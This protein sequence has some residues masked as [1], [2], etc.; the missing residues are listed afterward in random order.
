MLR[1]ELDGRDVPDPLYI[2]VQAL[3]GR[4]FYLQPA[5]LEILMECPTMAPCRGG[6]LCE[7][8]GIHKSN[9]ILPFL[10]IYIGTGKTVMMIGLILATR[11]QISLPEQSTDDE[12]A[13]LTPLAFRYFPSGNFASARGRFYRGPGQLAL[14]KPETRVPSLVE[15]LLH[16]YRI[17]PHC[18]V[19]DRNQS[20]RTIEKQD[21]VQSL[22][23]A[24]ALH[25]NAPFYYHFLAEPHNLKRTKRNGCALGPR[26]MYL[27]S[28]T[29]VIVPPNLL[30]QWDREITKHC[31]M[32][33]RVL[34]VRSKTPLPGVRDLATDYDVSTIS[35]LL[36]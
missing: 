7:E 4:V 36:I 16:H 26:I 32:P 25:A 21:R 14:E 24:N 18:D 27:T 3:D 22:P 30:S 2:S 8:L 6:I 15:L 10:T 5:T 17:S 1:N 34:I 13:A 31:A 28:A 20:E 23:L 19:P 35:T 9:A 12:R 29:L 33:L 11:S